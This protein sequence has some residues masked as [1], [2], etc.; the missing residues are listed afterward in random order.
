VDLVCLCVAALLAGFVDSI[1][2]GGGLIQLPALFIFLPPELS[3]STAAVFG[4]NK[5]SS[6]CGTSVAAVQY[7]R[8]IPVNWKS[9]LPAGFAAFV[10]SFLGA[11][12]VSMLD[13]HA[14]RPL[15]L[16]L[17]V[18]AGGESTTSL[19]GT[20]IRILAERRRVRASRSGSNHGQIVAN[21]VGEYHR[22]GR[23]GLRP[24]RQLP[25]LQ[26]R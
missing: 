11:R 8:R 16:F 12:L 25:A 13:G 3:L 10:F 7:S 20:G 6:I 4:T 18:A 5:L 2:G 21:H 22:I 24:A 17:L 19:T 1:V 23:C 9:I 15:I 14:L 26:D